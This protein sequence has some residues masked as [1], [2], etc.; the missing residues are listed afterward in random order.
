MGY[1]RRISAWQVM[2]QQLTVF[3]E[4]LLD[5]YEVGAANNT[6]RYALQLQKHR[7]LVRMALEAAPGGSARR[8][9]VQVSIRIAAGAVAG[10]RGASS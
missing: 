9:A 10:P 5:L 1:K 2:H 3:T 7:S 6:D 4:L 8:R